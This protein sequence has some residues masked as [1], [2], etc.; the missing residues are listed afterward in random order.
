MDSVKEAKSKLVWYFRMLAQKAGIGWTGDNE[1]EV[2]SIVD[3]ILRA[4]DMLADEKNQTM[5]KQIESLQGRLDRI[6]AVLKTNA[7]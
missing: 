2:E 4:A 1:C 6:E 5:Q 7:E 3:E